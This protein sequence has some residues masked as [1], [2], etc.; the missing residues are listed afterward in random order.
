MQF[1]HLEEHN[2]G[3]LSHMKRAIKLSIYSLKAS[4][5]F[6]IHAI[7]PDIFVDNGSKKI[8]EIM[9]ELNNIDNN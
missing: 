5:Y 7:Y 2:I 3:Y 1:V 8:S 9:I 4:I 6:L